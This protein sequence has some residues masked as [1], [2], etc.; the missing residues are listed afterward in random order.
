M[1]GCSSNYNTYKHTVATATQDEINLAFKKN[2]ICLLKGISELDDKVSN[3][4]LIAT[5]V[6]NNC[7][8]YARNIIYTLGR[9][10]IAL[11]IKHQNQLART[12]YNKNLQG[13]IYILLKRR[14]T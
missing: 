1:S 6:V 2:N 10:K 13:V 3:A 14:R 11:S 9:G 12:L 5:A 8:R 7:G 4:N